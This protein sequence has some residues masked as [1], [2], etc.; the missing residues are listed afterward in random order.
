MRYL[1]ARRAKNQRRSFVREI[2]DLTQKHSIISF[3]GGLPNSKLFPIEEIEREI[4]ETLKLGREIFQYSSAQGLEELREEISKEYI[5]ACKEEILITSGSQQGLDLICKTFLDRGDEVIVESPTYLA[6]LNLFDMFEVQITGVELTNRGVDIDKLEKIFEIKKPKLFYIIPT[7]QNPTGWSWDIEIKEKVAELARKYGVIVVEDSPY[8]KLRYSGFESKNFDE[9]LPELT[10]S[11]GTF[12]KT[13]APDFRIGWIKAPRE[14][15]KT[16]QTM[17][18]NSDLQSSRFFQHIATNL[19]KNGKLSLHV[20]SLIEAYRSKRDCMAN[21]LKE[22]FGDDVKFDI[23]KGGMFFWV[24]FIGIDSM[25]LFELSI[26]EGVAFVPAETFFNDIKSSSY[27]RLNFTS[28]SYSQIRD[29]IKRVKEA[30]KALNLD[31]H[32][33]HEKRVS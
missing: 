20:E 7:F 27:A 13:L 19:I 2:L 24:K 16:L 33:T 31:F 30:Y 26:K 15:I 3:A 10:I 6:A 18:E 21:A 28:S 22:E 8:N 23:P 11:L 17:K 32:I 9:L 1:F 29:G 14:F 25:K 12:S 5:D 4:K